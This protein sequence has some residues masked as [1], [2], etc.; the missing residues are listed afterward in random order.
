MLLYWKIEENHLSAD[1]QE[2]LKLNLLRYLML[3]YNCDYYITKS[4]TKGLCMELDNKQIQRKRMMGY[5]IRA[6]EDIIEKEG[7]EKITIRKVA[8]LAAY[9]SA[10]LYNYFEDLDHLVLF[11][12]MKYLRAYTMALSSTIADCHSAHEVVITSWQVFCQYAFNNPQIFYNLFFNK[13]R[14]KL[15]E[16]LRQY[17]EIFP[18]DLGEYPN[19]I[20][21]M[22]R[23]SDIF[24]RNELLMLT[25]LPENKR[26]ETRIREPNRI[27]VY[28]LQALLAACSSG[29]DTRPPEEVSAE[30]MAAIHYLIDTIK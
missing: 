11:T 8:Q 26:D 27:M 22:L 15:G 12:L 28:T 29:L 6:A 24:R 7:V 30:M 10:T 2:F 9:N 19:I 3:L 25:L 14:E 1:S 21:E 13:H 4:I 23:Q 5:F 18:E 17:Y 20:S 16:T